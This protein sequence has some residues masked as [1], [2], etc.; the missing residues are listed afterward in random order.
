MIH[1]FTYHQLCLFLIL[2]LTLTV[3]CQEQSDK[4]ESL[5]TA[6]KF[7]ELYF[8]WRYPE[9]V[10]YADST[11]IQMLRFMVSQISDDDITLIQE[12]VSPATVD[13]KDV[14][15]ESDDSIVVLVRAK[16]FLQ[17]KTIGKPAILQKEGDFTILLTKK[18]PK[19]PWKISSR[20]QKV[21][22]SH[23]E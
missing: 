1:K 9:A 10:E 7:A 22:T 4:K 5:Q 6:R 12:K 21:S 16:D 14:L 23:V 17:M 3:S 13:I 8:N 11:C 2:A 18:G 15:F 20:P 19:S